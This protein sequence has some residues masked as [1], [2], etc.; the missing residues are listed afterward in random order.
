[1][2]LLTSV[3]DESQNISSFIPAAYTSGGARMIATA[4]TEGAVRIAPA[5]TGVNDGYAF[6]RGGTNTD[7]LVLGANDVTT[8]QITMLGSPAT[9]GL[10]SNTVMNVAGTYLSVNNSIIATAGAPG[11]A[12]LDTYVNRD[13]HGF[14]DTGYA[15]D[16]ITRVGAGAVTNPAVLPVGLYSVIVVPQGAGNEAAQASAHCYWSG[17]AWT[18]NGVSFN[19][20]AG[21]PNLAIG[22]ATGGA[23][24]EIGGASIPAGNIDVVFRQLLAAP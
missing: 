7:S 9:I 20:T 11:A 6:L 2:S 14:S 4:A 1:M 13:V 5:T 8:S 17:T 16:T 22:P 24:L 10:N 21:A 18:G 19:F 15:T 23:T 3:N 12:A